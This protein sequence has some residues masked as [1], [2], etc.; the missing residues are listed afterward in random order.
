MGV[1][2]MPSARPARIGQN[3]LTDRRIARRIVRAAELQ[4]GDGV[5]E[6]G[7]GRGALTRPLLEAE[8]RVLAV[9]LD[10]NLARDL[11]E[12]FR[13]NPDFKLIAQDALKFDP[14]DHFSEP[15]KLVAN[16]PYYV[17]TPIIRRMLAASPA[18]TRMIVMVQREVADAMTAKPPRMTLLS[19]MMQTRA[20]ARA[21]F[22]VPPRA[23]RPQP[24]VTSAVVRLDP[25]DATAVRVA[26]PTAFTDFAAA[27]FRAPRKQIRNSLALG[28]SIPPAQVQTILDAANIDPR[29]RPSTLTLTEWANLYNV[30]TDHK[31]PSPFT[32]EG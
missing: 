23:F 30:W 8:A 24:K 17:A 21:L 14:A 22:A 3:F 1:N 26:D 16:L 13:D 29:R 12:R 9:E 6:I 7:P 32:G 19:V 20:A 10:E 2:P 25:Y 5:L 11:S 28:L 31:I 27:G 18:P 4:P 15:Y